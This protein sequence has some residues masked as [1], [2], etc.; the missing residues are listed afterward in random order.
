MKNLCRGETRYE[1][2]GLIPVT[3]TKGAGGGT[4]LSR[5]KT[6]VLDCEGNYDQKEHGGEDLRAQKIEELV[7]TRMIE[8]IMEE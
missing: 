4:V 2:M 5:L 8:A 1:Y 6:R 3:H 7:G